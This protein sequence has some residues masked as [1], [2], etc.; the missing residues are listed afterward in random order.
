MS[1][2]QKISVLLATAMLLAQPLFAGSSAAPR[3]IPQGSVKFLDSGAVVDK[4]IPAPAGM[5]MAC[6]GQ[7][8]VEGNGLQLMGADKTVFAVHENADNFSVMVQKG[9]VDFALGANA[10]PVEFK[11]PF[12]TIDA[13]PY[14]LP[15]GTDSVVR[16]NLQVNDDKAILTLTQG[17][18]ELTNSE[19][20]KLIHAGNALVLAQA[21]TGAGAGSSAVVQTGGVGGVVGTGAVA[22]IGAAGT[23]LGMLVEEGTKNSDPLSPSMP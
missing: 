22:G 8:Y 18:L 15:A 7:C 16:G 14:L 11:T 6:N 19:G 2:F 9:S 17:S 23:G 4:E 1:K 12:D 3:L 13:K 10:K 20:Q 5:L 21:T